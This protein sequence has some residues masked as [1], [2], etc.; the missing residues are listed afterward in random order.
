MTA[1]MID[2]QGDLLLPT[3]YPLANLAASFGHE[4]TAVHARPVFS[5]YE[6]PFYAAR[7]LTAYV[8]ALTIRDVTSLYTPAS[9]WHNFPR[10]DFDA[11]IGRLTGGAAPSPVPFESTASDAAAPSAIPPVKR[12]ASRK[13]AGGAIALA[14]AG[15]LAW[16]MFGTEHGPKRDEQPQAITPAAQAAPVVAE[17]AAAAAPASAA[18]IV[19]VSAAPASA[20]SAL[21]MGAASA[22]PVVARAFPAATD[23]VAAKATNSVARDVA[24]AVPSLSSKTSSPAR[25]L[26][27]SSK[28]A[29]KSEVKTAAAHSR[30]SEIYPAPSHVT[31]KSLRA[32]REA[33]V[34]QHRGKR[35]GADASANSARAVA[36]DRLIATRDA[37]ADATRISRRAAVPLV[38]HQDAKPAAPPASR[39][40][41]VA[42]MYDMLQHSPT[43]DD[44]SSLAR[45]GP[46]GRV[47]AGNASSAGV[48]LSKQRVTDAPGEFMK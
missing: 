21:H 46:R 40:M 17:H 35:R 30:A 11:F 16:L 38:V 28:I 44:N 42:E 33:R 31:T 45:S 47:Q 19:S 1:P 2:V 8:S 41:S 26:H 10:P 37:Q 34:D 27:K 43:L 32:T 5:E 9:L 6:V 20:A 29:A 36:Y 14:S 13:L 12:V 24:S 23:P 3:L 15:A 48:Q 4:W 25:V 39:T 22:G 7:L 18:P